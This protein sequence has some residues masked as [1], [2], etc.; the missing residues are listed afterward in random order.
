MYN[1]IVSV[2]LNKLGQTA[3]S[4]ENPVVI[5]K[6]TVRKTIRLCYFNKTQP[7]LM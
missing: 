2:G 4:G 7:M 3:D 1:I 6:R 5:S